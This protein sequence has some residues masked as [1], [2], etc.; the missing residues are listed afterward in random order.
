MYIPEL[1]HR[2]WQCGPDLLPLR[3]SHCNRVANIRKHLFQLIDNRM[4]VEIATYALLHP[5]PGPVRRRRLPKHIRER[6][7]ISRQATRILRSLRS[8]PASA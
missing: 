7:K 8:L 4:Q 3:L 1:A 2:Q 6:R 5:P